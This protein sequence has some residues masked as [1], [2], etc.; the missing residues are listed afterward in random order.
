MEKTYA[1]VMLGLTKKQTATLRE[2]A[3]APDGK[4]WGHPATTKSLVNR[5]LGDGFGQ[6]CFRINDKGRDSLTAMHMRSECSGPPCA[7]HRP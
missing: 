7:I 4:A 1:E 6:F 3:S 5:G 2:A